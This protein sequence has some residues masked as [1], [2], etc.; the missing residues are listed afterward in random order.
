MSNRASRSVKRLRGAG[1]G[2]I[3]M[4]VYL[5]SGRRCEI[6]ETAMLPEPGCC[7]AELCSYVS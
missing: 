5:L 4:G 1:A 6:G 3:E 7:P 2:G